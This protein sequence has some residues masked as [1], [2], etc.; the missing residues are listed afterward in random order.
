VRDDLL[1]HYERELKFLR[2]RGPEFAEKYPKIAQRLGPEQ[3]KGRDPHVERMLEAFAFL[4]GR[5]HLKIDDEFPEITEALLGVLYPHYLRPIPSMSIVEFDLEPAQRNLSAGI[6]VPRGSVLYSP[7]VNGVPCKYRTCFDTTVWP[8]RLAAAQWVTPNRLEPSM[9]T[10][11]VAA[12]RLD[13][14]C[15]PGVTFDKLALRSLRFHLN[16]EGARVHGLYELLCGKCGQIVVRDP[17]AISSVKPLWLGP[18]R[19]RPVGFEENEAALPYP[20]RSFPGYRLLQEYFAF[21]D[22]FFFFELSGLAL[23]SQAGFKD[24]AEIIV[25]ISRFE[26]TERQQALEVG[27][28]EKT[29]RLNCTPIINL[30]PQTAE[31]ILL[32]HTRYD[33]PIVPDVSRQDALEIFSVDEVVSVDPA[34]RDTNVF[35]PFYSYRHASAREKSKMFWHS[36]RRPSAQRNSEAIDFYL[37]LVDMSG[38]PTRPNIEAVTVRLTCSNGDLPSRLPFGN[39]RGDLELEAAAPI[40]RIVMLKKPTSTTRPPAGRNALWRLISHLSLNHRSLVEEG[41]DALQHVLRLYNFS[42]SAFIQKQIEGINKLESGR[43]LARV[44]SENGISFARGTRVK[45]E[46]DEEQFVGGGVYLFASVLE[47]FMGLYASLNSFSQLI[48]GTTQ[49][50]EVLAEWLPRAGHKILT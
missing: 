10:D 50:R 35:Q 43:H 25:L 14:R 12:L 30:F 11:A 15:F 8:L 9:A 22:K 47:R 39:E 46:L 31:P 37:S 19:L 3:A 32:S 27:V 45:L 1:L 5:V 33:Y 44:L 41:K 17:S 2:D 7:P 49:R 40:Q 29:V 23:L 16:G 48:A 21:P 4:T 42:D 6:S 20:L 34:S 26:R 13:L 18:N 38:K 36:S 28:S 24:R